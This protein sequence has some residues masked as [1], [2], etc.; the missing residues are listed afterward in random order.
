[1]AKLKIL[2]ALMVLVSLSSF[3]YGYN[4]VVSANVLFM[5]ASTCCPSVAELSASQVNAKVC[6]GGS[7]IVGC[8]GVNNQGSTIRPGDT[9]TTD[10]VSLTSGNTYNFCLEVFGYSYSGMTI[11]AND[12]T[13]ATC[14]L[15]S[16]SGTLFS[17]VGLYS[18]INPPLRTQCNFNARHRIPPP[19]SFNI[20]I[21]TNFLAP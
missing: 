17:Y 14:T 11:S 21:A 10:V 6:N 2:M 16:Y 7:C 1:M 13:D 20:D 18:N 9:F 5:S 8:Q 12:L 3:A 15:N 4:A 19:G